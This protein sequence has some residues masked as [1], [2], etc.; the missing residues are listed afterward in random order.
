MYAPRKENEDN[1]VSVASI[2]TAFY[3]AGAKGGMTMGF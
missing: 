3:H 1:L 2:A